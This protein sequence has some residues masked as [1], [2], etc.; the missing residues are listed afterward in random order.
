V[1]T[2]QVGW[3]MSVPMLRYCSIYLA[4][5]ASRSCMKDAT[6][7]RSYSSSGGYIEHSVHM[8]VSKCLF[9]A[10]R[11]PYGIDRSYSS[12]EYGPVDSSSHARNIY[13]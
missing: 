7:A 9:G 8:S 6:R 1:L 5:R 2:Q 13:T 10:E 11:D 3:P 12:S 4:S